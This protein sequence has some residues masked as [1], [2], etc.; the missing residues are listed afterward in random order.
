MAPRTRSSYHRPARPTSLSSFGFFA[1]LLHVASA[2]PTPQSPPPPPPSPPSSHNAQDTKP[3]SKMSWISPQANDMFKPGELIIFQWTAT[4]S[5]T[6]SSGSVSG[7]YT[8]P[9]APDS[10]RLCVSGKKPLGHGVGALGGVPRLDADTDS[11]PDSEE[12]DVPLSAPAWYKSSYAS[13]IPPSAV[14]SGPS[15]TP[16]PSAWVATATTW[17]PA[18][19][20]VAP[21]PSPSA[22][23][24]PSAPIAPVAPV[25]PILPVANDG[26]AS[27]HWSAAGAGSGDTA[28][29][30]TAWDKRSSAPNQPKN[31]REHIRRTVA[32]TS[33]HCG[34]QM[35]TSVQQEGG[36]YSVELSVDLFCHFV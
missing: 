10:F 31:P 29:A 25:A 23:A 33:S 19:T 22:W 5:S 11:D 27:D 20:W 2:S 26:F 17:G 15:G 21:S 35:W 18:S 36:T 30:D 16:T 9:P 6:R 13:A 24:A 14:P 8:H 32:P 1:T 28:D 7:D 4:S 12:L 3:T 34:A